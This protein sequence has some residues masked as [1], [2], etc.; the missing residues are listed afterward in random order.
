MAE[1]FGYSQHIYMKLLIHNIKALIS[2][3]DLRAFFVLKCLQ[4]RRNYMFTKILN[5]EKRAMFNKIHEI[6]SEVV[7]IKKS[8]SRYYAKINDF[9][10]FR[11]CKNIV[12]LFM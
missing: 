12:S 1:M 6:K 5:A 2:L 10:Y 9:N 11:L 7:F 8:G 3:C 4:E